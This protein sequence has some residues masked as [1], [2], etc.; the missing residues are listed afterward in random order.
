MIIQAFNFQ[1]TSMLGLNNTCTSPT[2]RIQTADW[3]IDY[4]VFVS[5]CQLLGGSLKVLHESERLTE[6]PSPH[7]HMQLVQFSRRIWEGTKYVH[8]EQYAARQ[9]VS[10][11]KTQKLRSLPR[12]TAW[13]ND[14]DADSYHHHPIRHVDVCRSGHAAI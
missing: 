9:Q 2:E 4:S 6:P 10:S 3:P 11:R 1:K 8:T 5:D 7:P 14:R 13:G 12:A